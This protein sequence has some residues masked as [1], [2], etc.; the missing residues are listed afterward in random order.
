MPLLIKTSNNRTVLPT[1]GKICGGSSKICEVIV[2][3][4]KRAGRHYT[5]R[6][7]SEADLDLNYL[8]RQ[9]GTTDED[10]THPSVIFTSCIL[11]IVTFIVLSVAVIKL[12]SENIERRFSG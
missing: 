1:K 5:C 9:F 12:K 2:L 4:N 11:V 6:R 3:P 7:S 10:S 8:K